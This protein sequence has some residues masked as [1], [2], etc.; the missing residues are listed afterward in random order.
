MRDIKFRA[1]DTKK[2]QMILNVFDRPLYLEFSGFLHEWSA[3]KTALVRASN[4]PEEI[5]LMQFTGLKDKNGKEIWEGDVVLVSHSTT[6]IPL[7]KGVVTF[8]E[9]FARFGIKTNGGSYL[10]MF[11]FS[12]FDG[13]PYAKVLGNIYENPEL[14]K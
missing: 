3:K 12:M 5:V 1:W 10:E 7:Y 9:K 4:Y 8:E 11:G 6:G 2:N 13:D 14:L